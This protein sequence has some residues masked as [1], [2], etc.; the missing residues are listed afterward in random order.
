MRRCIRHIIALFILPY[1]ANCHNLSTEN[2]IHVRLRRSNFPCG[3]SFVPC[4]RSESNLEGKGNVVTFGVQNTP[5][6]SGKA[7]D[8]DSKDSQTEALEK[9]SS[10]KQ[11]AL[12]DIS[13]IINDKAMRKAGQEAKA[14]IDELFN[15]TEPQLYT[16]YKAFLDEF[17]MSLHK[18]AVQ[19]VCP[20]NLIVDC[21]PG[22]Y[23]TYSGHCNNVRNP[24]WGAT[25]EPMQRLLHPAYA[26]G[27]STPRVAQDGSA[28]PSARAIS[29]RIFNATSRAANNACSLLLA[30]WSQ[31]VYEDLAMVGSN[32][33]FQQNRTIPI[34]CCAEEHPECLPILTDTDDKAYTARGQCIP[35]ARSFVAPREN[36]TLGVREQ[37][38][39]VT[40]FIDGSHIY[41]STKE[42][43]D[44]LRLFSDG[45]LKSNP[46]SQRLDLLPPALDSK[47]CAS[48]SKIRPC[49]LTGSSM[50][51]ILPTNAAFHTIWVRQHNRL[52]KEL[53]SLNPYWNDERI[54]QETRRIV[55]AQLQHITF[56]E[57]LPIIIGKNQLRS[58]GLQLRQNSFDSDYSIKTNPSTL[59]EY[60]SAVGLFFYSLLPESIGLADKDEPTVPLTQIRHLGNTF[61]DPSLLYQRDKLDGL[62]R[63]LL[64]EPTREFGNFN[65]ELTEKFLR[66]PDLNGVDLAAMLIQQGRDHGLNGYV[67]WREACGLSRPTSFEELD[68]L[69]LEDGIN[70]TQLQEIYGS[71]D[72]IDLLVMGLAEKP[73]RGALVGPTFACIIAKQFE[74]VRHGDRFWYENFFQP[75]A[76]TEDQLNEIRQTTLASIICDNTDDIGM[77]QPNAFELPDNYGNCPM[78]C[79]TTT[80]INRPNIR[81]W[82]DQEQKRQLPITKETLEKALKLG[83]EQ[84]RRLE[85]SESGRISRQRNSNSGPGR[86]GSSA[87]QTHANLMAPKKESLDI[88]RTAGIL[89][90]ATNVLLRGNGLSESER[91]P[92]ELDL[93][94]LQRLLPEIDVS[95]VVNNFT[96]FLGGKS[97]SEC[98]PRPL[99]CDHTNKYRTLSGWCNN[100]R[101]PHYGNA[102]EPL[103]R[104]LDPAYDDGFDT[105][106]TKAK[107]GRP[108]PS[109]RRVSNAVHVDEAK[110]HVKFSHMVMQVGQ[111]VDH[112][113]T[114]SPIARGPNNTV[115]NCSRCDSHETLSIHC[116]PITIDPTDEF[117][118]SQHSDGSARCM[119]FARSLLGQ[120]TLGYRNQLN[121]LTSYLDASYI[122]GS[123]ECESNALRLFNRGRLNFTD[124]GHNKHALPQGTQEKMCVS[125]PKHPCFNAGDERN[126]EQPG[127]TVIH[128][129]LLRQ[130]N[131]IALALSQIN[132]FWS[133]EQLFQETRRI[134][135]S[136]MQHVIYS[137]LLP[138]IL[139]CETMARYDLTPRKTGYFTGYDPNCDAQISQELA[140]A[141]F[142]FGHTLIR[143]VFPRMDSSYKQTKATP[144]EL[145]L[146][147]NNVSSL[148]DEHSGHMESILMGLLGAPG[149]DFD[150]HIVDAVRNHLFQRPGG[151]LTGLDLP[152]VNIQRG[153]DHGIPG[154]NNYREMCGLPKAISFDD[155]LGSMDVS[156]VRALKS[157]YDNVNDIDLFPGLMSE[158]PLKGALVGPMLACIIAEQFQRLKRCDRFYYENND[159]AGRFTP[160]QLAEIRKTTLSKMICES[161]EYAQKIQPN[162]FLLPDDLTNAPVTCSELPSMDLYAWLD[163]QFCVVDQRIINLGKT[164]RITPCITCTCTTEGPECHSVTIENCE[165]LFDEYLLSE[166]KQDTVCVIQCARAIN[167]RNSRFRDAKE[168]ADL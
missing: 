2:D 99:P 66:G 57:W 34:P 80:I 65:S 107:S 12:R 17:H 58:N 131:Q 33:L 88:A 3:K 1:L 54:Y 8:F 92:A 101:F 73:E 159:P 56:N 25:Y 41:G 77:V 40:S 102:F 133:D 127:L 134:M 119:P 128:T 108:L 141:A 68:A 16:D 103:R 18:S 157:V 140:T 121:Q 55:I 145:E 156:A 118:P 47:S 70:S 146:S 37:G 67:A 76:F 24:L 48:P 69:L 43:A 124:L 114:H 91:L 27:V 46:Q 142:R 139:G 11:S 19:T 167:E 78:S 113:M 136:K 29:R 26:D 153:R 165:T 10:K 125:K 168:F 59:N 161:S 86:S 155:L 85:E 110:F 137:E 90:E 100:L 75:S 61:N 97:H 135:I 64:R 32:R 35:Y 105:P 5:V 144:M 162:A 115:L 38:N 130:H 6:D 111:I 63:F 95:R 151:P 60:A 116:F 117:F 21:I 129:V 9:F 53:K 28:L 94:T 109:A 143:N 158:K 72:D 20:V 122:Y 52:A 147:F 23:R 148:Y 98:L 87:F 132:N 112:D 49:F 150:R 13:R 36:C 160:T 120:L 106:R 42:L 50:T 104:L 166:I 152:A 7:L 96:F 83:A 44:E 79:N 138:V 74:K 81:H 93:N 154:Y 163:R 126:N 31:F 89:R 84:Y 15:V 71:V 82:I 45:L 123:T 14:V 164:K 51:N 62:L 39:L 149:M 22:K 4:G 30:Q